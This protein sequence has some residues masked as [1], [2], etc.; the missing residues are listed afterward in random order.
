MKKGPEEQEDRD[1]ECREIRPD[2]DRDADAARHDSHAA[3]DDGARTCPASTG[4]GS[5]R[6]VR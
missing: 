5:H 3:H 6:G 2:A 1:A 4:R